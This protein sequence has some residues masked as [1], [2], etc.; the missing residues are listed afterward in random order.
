MARRS[1]NTTTK[2]GGDFAT[3]LANL[4]VPFGLVLAQKSLEKY[5]KLKT[6]KAEVNKPDTTKKVKKMVPKKLVPNKRSLK[7]V[8]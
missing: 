3:D 8:V 7:T 6:P 2:H 4:S 1:N 5:L